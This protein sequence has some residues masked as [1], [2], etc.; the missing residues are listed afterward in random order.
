MAD[1]T[2]TDEAARQEVLRL[3]AELHGDPSRD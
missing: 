3:E 2:D 1:Q